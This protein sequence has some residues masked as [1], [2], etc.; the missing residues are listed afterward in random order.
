METLKLQV[1]QTGETFMKPQ[2]E[3]TL[4]LCGSQQAVIPQ[5]FQKD[6]NDFQASRKNTGAETFA[7]SLRRGQSQSSRS[8]AAVVRPYSLNFDLTRSLCEQGCNC[9][10]H[11][12]GRIRS[13]YYLNA[14]FGSLLIG[15]TGQPWGARTCNGTDCRGRS[16]C[17]TYSYAFPQWFLNRMVTLKM[18]H[19]QSGGPE[20]CLRVVRVRSHEDNI[21]D[22]A[23]RSMEEVSI[24]CIKLLLVNG[25]ASVLDVDPYGRSA[26]QV[27]SSLSYAYNSRSDA[28][29]SWLLFV[30]DTTPLHF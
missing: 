14:V 26:L 12:R 20:L 25:E 7:T 4:I 23:T 15:Y 6:Y 10:C 22:V 19:D 17:I 29:N 13:P 3:Q 16:T 1:A 11:K 8:D 28:M 9:A 27:R 2:A 5:F 21:F 18:V 30:G 24:D